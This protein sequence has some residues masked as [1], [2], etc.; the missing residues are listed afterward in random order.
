MLPP[1]KK[2]SRLPLGSEREVEVSVLCAEAGGRR[3]PHV[4]LR[5]PQ[6]DKAEGPDR[7]VVR[8]HVHCPRV[9][10]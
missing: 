2:K 8:V 9:A 5:A 3:L 6:A 4:H 10:V 1:L 7:P